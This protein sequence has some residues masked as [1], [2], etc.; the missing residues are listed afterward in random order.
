MAKIKSRLGD[1]S[2]YYL[3][4]QKNLN[5]LNLLLKNKKTEE[6]DYIDSFIQ[7]L[8]RLLSGTNMKAEV[9]GRFKHFYSI[10]KKMYEKGKE[11]DDIYDLMGV[12]VVVENKDDC[13]HILS[14][15]H[16]KYTPVPG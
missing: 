1:L 11:F 7:T 14:L 3:P 13:Y 6:K 8:N 10:Y 4:Q 12:R 2:F 5:L 15:I 16:N 9:K